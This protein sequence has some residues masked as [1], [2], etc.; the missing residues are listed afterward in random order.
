M[1][2]TAGESLSPVPDPCPGDSAA[3]ALHARPVRVEPGCG[4]AR[5][6]AAR[7]SGAWIR[8]AVP[9]ALRGPCR[10][11]HP[12]SLVSA[13][14][15]SAKGSGSSP[16]DA[17]PGAPQPPLGPGVGPQA[18]MGQVP[19]VASGAGRE[20]LPCDPRPGGALAR[21]FAAITLPIPG[22]STGAGAGID[23]GV[24]VTLALSDGHAYQAPLTET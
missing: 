18:R 9:P 12:A 23:R 19:A 20:V 17:G 15:D 6:V 24:T 8:R 2:R 4:A 13:S 10:V 7:P 16:P 14:A 11:P 1:L 5:L 3:V 21:L 22:P